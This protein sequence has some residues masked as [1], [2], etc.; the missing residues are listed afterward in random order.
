MMDILVFGLM[1][2]PSISGSHAD[3]RLDSTRTA[4]GHENRKAEGNKV[5]G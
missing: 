3:S 4:C 5:D 1:L 2:S